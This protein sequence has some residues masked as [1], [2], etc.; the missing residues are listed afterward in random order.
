MLR[1]RRSRADDAGLGILL[2]GQVQRLNLVL[3]QLDGNRIDVAVGVLRVADLEIIRRIGRTN[4]GDVGNLAALDEFAGEVCP[5]R[6][7][8]R[9]K[10]FEKYIRDADVLNV[11]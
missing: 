8:G 6:H 1:A 4:Y 5:Q 2:V 3:G 9:H 10:G 11:V 7:Q